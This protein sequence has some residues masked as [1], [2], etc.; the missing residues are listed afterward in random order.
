MREEGVVLA[1]DPGDRVR[2]RRRVGDQLA[3][4]L[5]QELRVEELLGVF[6]LVQGLALVEPF[7]ALKTNEPTVGD[8]GQRLGQL[9]LAD[10]RRALDEHGAAHA[11]SQEHHRADAAVG[12]VAGV[13]EVLLDVLRGLEHLGS[14]V[15]ELARSV[16][17][18]RVL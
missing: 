10:A 15:S 16:A 11:L 3:D 5:A 8:L 17:H 1:G 18:L 9:G 12:D 14:C 7:V 2:Q 13:L 6:P 4:A